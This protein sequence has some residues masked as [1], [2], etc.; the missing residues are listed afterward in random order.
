VAIRRDVYEQNPWVATSLYNAFNAAKDQAS[1]IYR[2]QAAHMHRLFM[3][4]WL[5]QHLEETQALM[6][7]DVWPYGL[8][9]NYTALDTFLRYHHEHG[10]SQRRYKP[11]ELFV[12]ETLAG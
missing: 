8:E 7:D 3:I 5:T 1:S 2:F 4:P 9:C 10:L 6:G 11:E 12:S